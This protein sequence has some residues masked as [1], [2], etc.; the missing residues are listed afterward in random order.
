V[1][2]TQGAKDATKTEEPK[3]GNSPKRQRIVSNEWPHIGMRKTGKM[4]ERQS[5]VREA[6]MAHWMQGRQTGRRGRGREGEG[7]TIE[8]DRGL[9][10][11]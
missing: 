6:M 2:Y 8:E 5:K 9:P 7:Q 4:H 1:T 11:V 10:Y 3:K